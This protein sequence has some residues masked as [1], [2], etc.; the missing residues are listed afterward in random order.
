[1]SQNSTVIIMSINSAQAN[2]AILFNWSNYVRVVLSGLGVLTNLINIWTFASPLLKETS[3]RFMMAKSI[4]NFSYV[5]ISFTNEFIVNCLNCLSVLNYASA[6]YV[7]WINLYVLNCLSFFRTQLDLVIALHT[8]SILLNKNWTTKL[9]YYWVLGIIG[10]ITVLYN[11]YKPFIFSIYQEPGQT[12]AFISQTS[13]GVSETN[14]LLIAIQS[15]IKILMSSLL[16]PAINFANLVLFRQRYGNRKIRVI[17]SSKDYILKIK[18]ITKSNLDFFYFKDK[19]PDQTSSNRNTTKTSNNHQQA[20]NVE[21]IDRPNS[22]MAN[23]FFT[24]MVIFSSFINI[25]TQ[26]PFSLCYIIG[27]AGLNS[28]TFSVVNTVSV[29]FILISPDLDLFLYYAYNKLYRNVLNNRLKK[30]VSL[31]I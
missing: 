3:Y 6:V 4:I 5:S 18:L 29:F 30:I 21:L 10:V 12:Q 13:F 19:R 7:I 11:G 25:L 24:S 31:F 16:F 1:M 15:F 20:N 14:K 28:P 27:F 8:L 23:K 2:S 22:H 26:L 9:A 17:N